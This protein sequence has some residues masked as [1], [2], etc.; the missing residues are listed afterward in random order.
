[1]QLNHEGL[2][3]SGPMVRMINRSGRVVRIPALGIDCAHGHVCEVPATYCTPRTKV[4][5]TVMR[6]IVADLAPQLEV[7]DKK[8]PIPKVAPPPPGVA[9]LV[10]A[11]MSEGEAELL[12]AQRD[13]KAP[14]PQPKAP[15]AAATAKTDPPAPKPEPQGALDLL[16]DEIDFG[17]LSEDGEE[18]PAE[19]PATDE[20]PKKGR[21][22]KRRD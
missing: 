8:A 22:K 21:G 4:N 19:E 3:Y 13:G 7:L 15:A 14:M 5:G 12:V 2:V 17:D 9:D 20:A 16:D 18:P 6:S 10:E 1:M 11:G